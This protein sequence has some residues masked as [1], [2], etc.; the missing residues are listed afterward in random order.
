MA[1]PSAADLMAAIKALTDDMATM[2]LGDHQSSYLAE[3]AQGRWRRR[4]TDETLCTDG[5]DT[6][7]F[8]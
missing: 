2:G 5:T 8:I 6:S 7:Y 1:E 3:T 4:T